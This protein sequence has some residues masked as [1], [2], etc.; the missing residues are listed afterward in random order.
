MK[1]MIRNLNVNVEVFKWDPMFLKPEEEELSVSSSGL[2]MIN[3]N[4]YQTPNNELCGEE[5]LIHLLH[6]C[7]HQHLDNLH[8]TKQYLV[9]YALE[10]LHGL[11]SCHNLDMLTTVVAEDLCTKFRF[12][13]EIV[14]CQDP[15]KPIICLDLHLLVENVGE[16]SSDNGSCNDDIMIRERICDHFRKLVSHRRTFTKNKLLDKLRL[17]PGIKKE[18]KAMFNYVFSKDSDSPEDCA[19]CSEKLCEGTSCWVAQM[20]CCSHKFHRG[21]ICEWL[22]ISTGSCPLCRSSCVTLV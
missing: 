13:P 12:S 9:R 7:H 16:V 10:D 8:T 14:S 5:T 17:L 21:C 19:I 11:R 20:D 3:V 15:D 22:L 18:C 2:L 6:K 1:M 4:Y